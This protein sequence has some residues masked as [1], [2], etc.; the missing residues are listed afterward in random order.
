MLKHRVLCAVVVL[1]ATYGCSAEPEAPER[2]YS[3]QSASRTVPYLTDAQQVV[4]VEQVQ[5]MVPDVPLDADR[6]SEAM[7]STCV[8]MLDEVPNLDRVAA[9]HL[10][11]GLQSDLSEETVTELILIARAQDWCQG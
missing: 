10:T 2:E 9:S 7:R 6:V 11:R 4:L 3:T 1:A 5:G 8:A